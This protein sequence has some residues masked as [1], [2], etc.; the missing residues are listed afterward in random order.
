MCPVIVLGPLQEFCAE[1]EEVRTDN[2][3][4][5]L[6]VLF[7]W[8]EVVLAI[9]CPIPG[10]ITSECY[11]KEWLCGIDKIPIEGLLYLRSEFAW[12]LPRGY[13]RG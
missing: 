8:S 5:G 3:A 9:K 6:T 11:C 13:L 1:A 2:W 10:E 4:L 7:A 12:Q